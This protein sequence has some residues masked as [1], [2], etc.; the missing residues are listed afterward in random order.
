[1]R[2]NSWIN[3]LILFAC[4]SAC[5]ANSAPTVTN[6]MATPQANGV[7]DIS[8]TLSD[9]DGDHCTI[10]VLILHANEDSTWKMTPDSSS[11]SGDVGE[12][13]IAP[14]TRQIIWDSKINLRGALDSYRVMIIAD[15][16]YVPP[17]PLPHGMEFVTI[18]DSGAGMR[19]V[20]GRP[21]NHDHRGFKGQMSKYE[22]TNA[23]YCQYLNAALGTGDVTVSGNDVKGANGSNAGTDYVGQS[24]Y[25]GDGSGYTGNGATNGGASRIH[26]NAGRFIV[27]SD[28]DNHPVTYVSWYGASA[29]AAYYGY[30]LPTEWEWQT[31]ADYDGSY[32]YGCGVTI[33]NDIANYWHSTHPNGTTLVGSFGTYGYGLC[34]MAGNVW[35]WTGTDVSGI[36]R[37]LLGGSWCTYGHSCEPANRYW[38]IPA[39]SRRDDD[40]GFR[41]CTSVS[42][43]D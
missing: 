23:Q 40:Y 17:P 21:F 10:S 43:L 25:R 3:I 20:Y 32:I 30:R 12:K 15:D 18:N 29:F 24:Y 7:V 27:D 38:S 26:Y 13:K 11:L 8:Y 36:D 14:G 5:W 31:V 2:T 19:S 33:T 37:V 34:D 6:V 35:E 4:T 42:A 16:E 1:M 22:T 28:F 39:R 41:V 9:A